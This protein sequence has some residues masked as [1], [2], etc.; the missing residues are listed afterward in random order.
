MRLRA[1]IFLLL[2]ASVAPLFVPTP[3]L[4]QTA[5]L[6]ITDRR[7][8]TVLQLPGG[9]SLDVSISFEQVVGLNANALD[10]T[11]ALIS[12]GDL[13]ILG[14]MPSPSTSIPSGLPVVIRIEPSAG[15][16]LSFSGVVSIGLH[17]HNLT[18]DLAAPLV[19]FSASNGGPF[20]D[21][22][23]RVAVGSYRVDGS[24]G[25]F[26]E[27]V[28]ALDTRPPATIA[29]EKFGRL[30]AHLAEHETAIPA[31]VLTRLRG[32]LAQARSLAATGLAV[33]AISELAAFIDVVKAQGGAI[34]DVWR[35]H[36]PRVNVSGLLRS[37]AQ[38]LQFTLTLQSNQ[39]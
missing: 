3:A 36:D 33:P 14:R 4:S 21:I 20:R 18:L 22:T 30:D 26:S 2:L 31:A 5:A 15:S 29:S 19:L 1:T 10:V 39:R 24:G 8:E 6:S 37:A 34:P 32:H 13:A 11:A 25:G 28:I 16:A 9:L 23:S 12:P 38:T 7:A 17:T 27:F 35:A